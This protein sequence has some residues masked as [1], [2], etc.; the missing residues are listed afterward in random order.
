MHCALPGAVIVPYAASAEV[1]RFQSP[2]NIAC[3]PAP[4]ASALF[5]RATAPVFRKVASAAVLLAL[6]C[7]E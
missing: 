4:S 7:D 6:R 3:T 1:Y 2:M 5:R